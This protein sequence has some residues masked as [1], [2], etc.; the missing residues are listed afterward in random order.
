MDFN[1]LRY[2][3]ALQVATAR[4]MKFGNDYPSETDCEALLGFFSVCYKEFKGM[5]DQKIRLYLEG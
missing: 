2:D 3:L 4:L 5:S 1:K